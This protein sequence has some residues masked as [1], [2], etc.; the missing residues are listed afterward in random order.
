MTEMLNLTRRNLLKT[1]IA[2]GLAVT[3]WISQ[4]AAALEN[5]ER[6]KLFTHGVASGDP[7]HTSSVIW[8]RV[9]PKNGEAT[10]VNWELADDERFRNVIRKGS[11]KASAERDFTVKVDVDGLKPGQM[12]YYRFKADG[13]YSEPGRTRTLPEGKV[14]S[15]TIALASCSNY[16]FGYF[17][18]YEVISA[19]KDIQFVLHLGDYLYEYGVEGWGGEESKKLGREHQP[20]HE[21]VSLADYR[22]RHGQYKSDPASRLMH[23]AHP[24][25][26][27]WDDHESANN[28][29]LHGAQN[30]QPDEGKW[31]ERRDASVQAYFEWMP[32]RDPAEGMR[33]DELWR[34]FEFGDLATMIKLETRH[35]GREEQVDYEEYLPNIKTPEQRQQFMDEVMGNPQRDMLSPK[36]KAF[37]KVHLAQSVQKKQPWR[38]L[39]NQIPM[40]RI[41]LP[42]VNDIAA[43]QEDKTMGGYLYVGELDLPWYSD[44]WDG[45]GGAREHFYQMSREQGASD[46]LVLT[47]DSHSFWANELFDGNGHPMGVELGTSGISSPGDFLPYGETIA[48]EMDQRMANHNR[49]VRWTDGLHNG[50]VKLTVTPEKAVA[51]YVT[52]NTVTSTDYQVSLLKRIEIEKQGQHLSYTQ[53][54]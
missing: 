1:T 42:K 19:D 54:V 46:L 15:L 35:T 11:I 27:I 25:I 34:S 33:A 49:E 39:G 53:G 4:V 37:Y 40:A 48:A 12:Y 43:K 26:C 13:L 31:F 16:A 32:V 44:T 30:H 20:A 22:E 5:P 14:D 50:F 45:Y 3:P 9:S 23:A 7:T 10:L 6:L 8:T 52:V 51:D 17:N 41:H 36:M 28:P 29:F 21:I 2:S 18:A 24:L 38:L 47:G